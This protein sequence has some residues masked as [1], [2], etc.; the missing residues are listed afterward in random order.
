MQLN[1]RSSA[2]WGKLV[3]TILLAAAA[4]AAA[5]TTTA[6]A[7]GYTPTVVREVAAP[8]FAGAY[9]GLNA[10]AA[11]GS[12][13]YST[14][15][16]CASSGA[17]AVF[18]EVGATQANGTAVGSSGTGSLSSSGFTGGIQ[19][20]YNWQVGQI[21]FG[22]EG[23]F[24]AFDLGK[25]VRASGEFPST[26][27]GDAYTLDESMST[28]WL[29]TLRG[30]LGYTVTPQLLLYG[31]AGLALT[32][33]SFSS[34]YADNAID[35]TFPGGTGSASVS[36]VLTG[37]TI[38]GGGEWLIDGCWSI[39]AEYLYL[40]FGSTNLPVALSN[41]EDYTQTMWVD[42]DLSAQVARVG[43]NYRP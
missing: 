31:T 21:V 33:F 28:D 26:F 22:G 32:D 10:G 2:A 3:R 18:C 24:G 7:D 16:G 40:D 1:I 17:N 36:N 15:P 8:S 23:D 41:T 34:S 12:S 13:D 35:A 9:I 19:G 29:I 42:A 5:L 43:V 37:W 30:R 6:R 20:G 25:S 39:K 38:G 4:A 14:N 27:L 11:W